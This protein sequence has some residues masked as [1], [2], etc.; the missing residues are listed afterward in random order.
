MKKKS[1]RHSQ[2]SI[3]QIPNSC[4][5]RKRK[6]N[7]TVSE[8]SIVG[9]TYAR[10]GSVVPEVTLVREAVAN[11]TK[12]ALLHILLDGVEELLLADLIAE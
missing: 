8:A 5:K 10:E 4:R 3:S 7:Q 2:F 1:A 9:L 6:K 12:L 11:I